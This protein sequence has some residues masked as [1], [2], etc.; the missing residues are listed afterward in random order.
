[1]KIIILTM[2]QSQAKNEGWD[3]FKF[4]IKQEMKGS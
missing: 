4:C 3:A 2:F 1:M